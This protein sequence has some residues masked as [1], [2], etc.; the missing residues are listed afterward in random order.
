MA[1]RPIAGLVATME[2]PLSW[3]FDVDC[4]SPGFVIAC[5]K[6]V[7]PEEQ[8]EGH[9]SLSIQMTHACYPLAV[10]QVGVVAKATAKRRVSID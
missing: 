6:S 5:F 3:L 1:L 10:A 8:P 7:V 4:P 2:I 9:K